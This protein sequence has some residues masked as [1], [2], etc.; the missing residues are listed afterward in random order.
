MYKLE[1]SERLGAVAEWIADGSRVAD[2]G[3]DHGLLPVFL[4][5]SGKADRVIATDV[6]YRPL[7]KAKACARRHDLDNKISFRICDGLSGILPGEADTVVIAGMGG[8]TI[9]SILADA[10]WTAEGAHRLIL[11]PMSKTEELRSFLWNGGFWIEAERLVKDRGSLYVAI[12][13]RGGAKPDIPD[14]G[15]LYVGRYLSLNGD[16]LFPEYLQKQLKRLAHAIAGAKRSSK[17]CDA[18]R[19]LDLTLAYRDLTKIWEEMLCQR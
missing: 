6:R 4:L 11:Q 9:A 13:A 12:L 14:A 19:L 7:E 8:E 1:L 3:T 2:I 16:P 15:D 10:P 17:A 18:K 5:Q